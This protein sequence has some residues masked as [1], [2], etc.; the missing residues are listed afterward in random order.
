MVDQTVDVYMGVVPQKTKK[1]IGKARGDFLWDCEI[2]VL[3]LAKPGAVVVHVQSE[4]RSLRMVGAPAVE[5]PPAPDEDRP[6]F[7]LRSHDQRIVVQLGRV[8]TAWHQTGRA[9]FGR[10]LG[11][12]PHGVHDQRRVG[13]SD[14]KHHVILVKKLSRLARMDLDRVHNR[15]LKLNERAP[16]EFQDCRVGDKRV[17]GASLGK[18]VVDAPRPIAEKLSPSPGL[19]VQEWT[20]RVAR[21]LQNRIR[22]HIAKDDVAVGTEFFQRLT[23]RHGPSSGS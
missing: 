20:K 21:F 3:L 8:L 14:G 17:D 23:V 4:A 11:Q 6:R 1:L 12:G 15:N 13:A 22:K 18:N 10:E 5:E 16:K 19:A 7:H 9:V 2:L